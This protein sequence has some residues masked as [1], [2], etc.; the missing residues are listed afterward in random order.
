MCSVLSF[1]VHTT[2][3]L[4]TSNSKTPRWQWRQMSVFYTDGARIVIAVNFVLND[5]TWFKLNASAFFR[6]S[7]KVSLWPL[8]HQF[9]VYF[10]LQFVFF[11]EQSYCTSTH[12]LTF[13][14]SSNKIKVEDH[15]SKHF[16]GGFPP[17]LH[18]CCSLSCSLWFLVFSTWSTV[19]NLS[20]EEQTSPFSTCSFISND[21]PFW[22]SHLLNWSRCTR[23]MVVFEVYW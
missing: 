22:I 13:S 19:A 12:T 2:P 4:P 10:C 3:S 23:F 17:A 15:I 7:L 21:G 1:T 18:F 16:A 8:A 20:G 14:F 6:C 11:P 9:L 5:A